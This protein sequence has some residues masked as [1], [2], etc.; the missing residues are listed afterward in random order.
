MT[1]SL[2]EAPTTTPERL[3]AEVQQFYA[4]HMQLLDDGHA[5]E[6]AKT[7]TEDGTFTAGDLPTAKG[8]QILTAAVTK[9]HA[10]LTAAGVQRR[11]W[12]GMVSVTPNADGSLSVRCYA[13][14]F[15][16]EKGAATQL[17]RTCVCRDTLVSVDGEWQVSERVVTRDDM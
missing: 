2:T 7:F 8:R 5:D 14:V 15:H 10:D 3:Y 4:R 9:A 12:H 13:L 16:T 1:A 6:W 11:H 17:H